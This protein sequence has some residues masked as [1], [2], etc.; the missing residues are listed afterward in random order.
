MCG[1]SI[2]LADPSF[3]YCAQKA[4]SRAEKIQRHRG[5]DDSGAEVVVFPEIALVGLG[6]QRLSIIDLTQNGHQPMTSPCGQYM[7]VFNGEIYNYREIANEL[8]HSNLIKNPDSDTAVALAAFARWGTSAFK[9]F[10]GMWAMAILDKKQATLTVSRDRLG[11]K[12]LYWKN[13]LGHIYFASE[14]KTII[15]MTQEN[16]EID[17]GVASR[18]LLQ[19]ITNADDRTFIQGIRCVPPASYSVIKMREHDSWVPQFKYFWQ[20]PYEISRDSLNTDPDPAELRSLL[21]DSVRLRLH[22]DVPVGILLSG[23]LDSSTI[24]GSAVSMGSSKP[25]RAFSVISDDPASNEEPYIDIMSDHAKC[26]VIKFKASS[27]PVSLYAELRECCW[28]NDQPIA[29]FSAIAYRRLVSL[30][31]QNGFRVLLSGQGADEQLAG[32]SKFFYFYAIHL[33]KTKQLFQLVKLFTNFAFNRTVLNEFSFEEARRYF[34]INLSTTG[35]IWGPSAKFDDLCSV[36]PSESCAK[37]EWLDVK[38]LSIP[39]LLHYEDRMS[40]S[41]GTEV[42]LPFLDYRIVEWLAKVPFHYKL[43]GGWTKKILR[44]AIVDLV[45]ESIRWRRDKRGFNL[46]EK[47]WLRGPCAS[48]VMRTIDEGMIC[49]RLGL[50]NKSHLKSTFQRFLKNGTGISYKRL[51]SILSLEEWIKG[52]ESHFQKKFA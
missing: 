45:P 46:P 25:L 6:H 15:A 37:R 9:R 35:N 22:A 51:F 36:G 32:Y 12:P 10:N 52:F 8:K 7:I 23:G 3:S 44:D 30:A 28:A 42:R 1:I 13:Y 2:I 29:G 43:C 26:K 5:P 19:S 18:F 38:S 27:D 20:H 49:E 14:V 34:L 33:L 24:L 11:V 21:T 4:L 50:I 17:Y 40:M 47:E 39:M 16:F 41:H 31:R 48:L